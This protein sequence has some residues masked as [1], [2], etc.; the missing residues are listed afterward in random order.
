MKILR[1]IKVKIMNIRVI[2]LNNK[3]NKY[4]LM[5]RVEI[6]KIIK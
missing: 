6:F 4:L 5:N 3:I 1:E 2:L